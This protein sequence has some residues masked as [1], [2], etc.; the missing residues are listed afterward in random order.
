[1]DL[2]IY[3]RWG[4][5]AYISQSQ[6]DSWDGY[7]NGALLESAVYMYRLEVYFENGH[8]DVFSGNITLVR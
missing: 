6:L 2:H 8:Y 7:Y 3:D 4:N 1:M 5:Q